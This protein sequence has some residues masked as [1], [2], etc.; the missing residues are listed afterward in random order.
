MNK[1]D[2]Y[3]RFPALESRDFALFWGGQLISLIG[4]WMQ[5]TTLPYLA[6]RISHNPFDLGLIGF[7]TTLPTFVLALPGGVLVERLDKRKTVMTLQ[8][9]MMLQALAM[10]LLAL[11]GQIAIWHIALLSLLLGTAS[12]I[13]ITARQSMLVELV[14]KERLP[15]AIA[16]Q[17]TVFNT[18]RVIGPSLVAPFLIL[19]ED[20]GEGWAFLANAVSYLFV[21]LGLLFVRTPFRAAPNPN[22]RDGTGEFKEGIRYIFSTP[23]ISM[24]ILMASVIGFI[25]FPLLQ[26][27]P[28]ISRDMLAQAGDTEAAQAA[29]NSLLY[30]AQGVGALSAALLLAAFNPARKGWLLLA[31]QTV[32]ALSLMALALSGSIPLTTV[33]ITLVGW[34]TVTTL[35]TMNTLIQVQAPDFLRGRVFSAYLWGLQGVAPFGSLLIGWAAQSWGVPNTLWWGGLFCLVSVS[36]VHLL[37]PQIRQQKS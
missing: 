4:T 20:G 35:A 5:N 14:G 2:F 12:A 23:L 15:N 28:V 10:G 32:F 24:V 37:Q 6:Y 3:K 22:K 26:Q 16:L 27:I 29:R 17:A 9:V 11:S 33:L 18:A 19:I 8:G 21:V 30:T 1:Q 31:G 34:G 25:G 36:A 13:E 7:A